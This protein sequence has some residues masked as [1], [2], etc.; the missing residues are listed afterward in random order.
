MRITGELAGEI[1]VVLTAILGVWALIASQPRA[2][3]CIIPCH[4]MLSSRYC[5]GQLCGGR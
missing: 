1:Y 5:V 3:E 4:S 2:E